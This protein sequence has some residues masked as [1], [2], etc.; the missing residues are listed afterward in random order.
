L[1]NSETTAA[2]IRE[3]IPA[4]A[5]R[6]VVVPLGVD[7]VYRNPVSPDTVADARSRLSLPSRYVLFL[8][9]IERRKNVRRLIEAFQLA[10]KRGLDHDLVL[11]GKLSKDSDRELRDAPLNHVHVLGFVQERDKP[12][13]Y[14]GAT[15]FAMP[16]LDE[17][18]GLPPLEA[19]A[20]GTPSLVSNVEIFGETLG[21]AALTAEPH[22]I[23]ALADGLLRLCGDD[24]LRQRLVQ[25]GRPRLAKYDWEACADQTY[26]AIVDAA[27]EHS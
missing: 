26:R 22:D 15:A 9:W 24:G 7:S 3:L 25:A 12:A 11:A 27:M 20:C 17:G 14:A 23:D 2:R 18:L 21:D 5:E 1:A 13:L 19:L 8:G 6:V 10:R 16:S 4:V